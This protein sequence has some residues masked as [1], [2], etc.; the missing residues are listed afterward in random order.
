MLTSSRRALVVFARVPPPGGVMA[1]LAASIGEAGALDA[2]RAL[3]ERTL[4]TTAALP[5]CNRTLAYA[6]DDG[7]AAMREWLGGTGR[8]EPQGLGDPG[9]RLQTAVG[10]RLGE[11]AD[12]VAIVGTDC[13][14][15]TAADIERAWAALDDADLV[16]GP[17]EGGDFW[18]VG[19]KAPHATLFHD[20]PWGTSETLTE[21][22][23]RAQEESLKVVLLGRKR[24]IS[25]VT[26]WREWQ[27]RADVVAL[28]TAHDPDTRD[29]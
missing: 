3:V 8:L 9:T 24:E 1:R 12:R 29:G 5:D 15:M 13:P 26:D 11:G 16:L 28:A 7:G 10:R 6:P 23:R 18:L 14:D 22:L 2:Y 19:L 20:V 4:A 17:T 25:T 27:A 21:T